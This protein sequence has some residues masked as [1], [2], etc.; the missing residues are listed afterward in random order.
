[1]LEADRS[2]AEWRALDEAHHVHSFTDPRVMGVKGTRVITRGDGVYV[3]DS[4]GAKLLDA[5]AGLW[6]VNVGYGRRELGEAARRQM[7]VLP[8]YNN[9]FQ[10]ATPQMIDLAS[11]ISEVTPP[12]L[13]HV[14]FANS[15]SEAIDT[16]IRLVRHF[17]RLQGQPHRQAFI[18][19]TLGYHG[20]TLAATSLGGMAHMHAMQSELLPG[21]AHIT[22]P[23]W[24]TLGG[25]L[26]PEAYGLK[27][28]QELE[29]KILELGPE[30]VAAFVGEPVQGAGGVIVPPSTYW[31]EIQR[32]CRKY[33]ILLV[34]DEVI[35]GFGRTGSW[36]GSQ[37]FGI[38][39]DLMSMAKGLS[40]GYAPISAVAMNAR[41][42]D[43]INQGGLIA[44]GYTYSGH[45]VACAVAIENIGIIR[46]EGLVERVR[47]D[48]GPYLQSRLNQLAEESPIVGEVR[49]VGLMAALQLVRDK[50]T[51]EICTP[52]DN[53]AIICREH[54]ADHGLI[55]RAL[56]Q[57]MAISPP[58]TITRDEIDELVSKLGD[59]LDHTARALGR[60]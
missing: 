17:W 26:T 59:A 25:D 48:V 13:D 3:W 32:I 16:V 23:H 6:C 57:A 60:L 22:Q 52:E 8:Y 56:G 28:A 10:T 2:T 49:G 12:G 45:P 37:T 51:R 38:E 15:G 35:C 47:D 11:L 55:A 4:D 1:M 36:F 50:T 53:A 41:V 21:F 30:N 27:A 43:A 31:P 5:M 34:A 58:L 40:S 18:G 14:V 44:H 19:R 46:R 7:D 9:H 24:Y 29:A 54:A 39:P 33:D 42:A 20:S